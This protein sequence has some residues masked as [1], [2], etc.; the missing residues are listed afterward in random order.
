MC[1]RPSVHTRDGDPV[2]SCPRRRLVEGRGPAPSR[3]GPRGNAWKTKEMDRNRA[4]T[5]ATLPPVPE[6]NNELNRARPD[7]AGRNATHVDKPHAR[8][9]YMPRELR[10]CD[11]TPPSS[12]ASPLLPSV[13]YDSLVQRY[14][15][16]YCCFSREYPSSPR[17][18]LPNQ[19]LRTPTPPNYCSYFPFR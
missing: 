18:P 7:G 1:P 15:E 4:P 12:P 2:S 13:C 9:T 3:T 17:E 6:E 19:V 14:T 5:L 10:A 8:C 16:V 11:A